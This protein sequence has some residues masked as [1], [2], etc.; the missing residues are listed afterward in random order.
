METVSCKCESQ[1]VALFQY[2]LRGME[3]LEGVRVDLLSTSF[4]Y[5]LRGMETKD[6]VVY[7]RT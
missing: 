2:F 1:N 3:T 4:Q 6:T 7:G 5:F